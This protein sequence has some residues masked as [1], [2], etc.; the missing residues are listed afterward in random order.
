MTDPE[1][2][3]QDTTRTIITNAKTGERSTLIGSAQTVIVDNAGQ[4]FVNDTH[5]V[6][7]A[8]GRLVHDIIKQGLY[9]CQCGRGPWA[10]QAVTFCRCGRVVCRAYCT[11][12]DPEGPWCKRCYR[13]RL[14]KRFL[15]WLRPSQ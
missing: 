15:R 1:S 4:Q 3:N 13:K 14:F 5:A 9:V 8:D 7:T 2:V 11:R 10:T 12:N 6:Q